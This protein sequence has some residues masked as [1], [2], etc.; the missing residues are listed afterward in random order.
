MPPRLGR[1]GRLKI[2]VS[3]VAVAPPSVPAPVK[4]W[5]TRDAITT[6]DPLDAVQLDNWYPDASGLSLRNGFIQFAFG[7]GV[8]SVKTLAEY[9]VGATRKLIA[10]CGGRLLDIS[11]GGDS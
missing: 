1:A 4:G 5:N 10:G 8:T 7:L 11:N 9:N 3:P 6:M 2:A